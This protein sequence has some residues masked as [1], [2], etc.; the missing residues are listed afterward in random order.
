M[1]R[2]FLAIIL[3][4][5]PL[6]T[7]ITLAIVPL[8]VLAYNPLVVEPTEP[9]AIIPIE[10]DPY[11]EHHYLGSLEEY[12]EM[13]ELTTEVSMTLKFSIWQ[14]SSRKAVPFGLILV[15]QNDDD[16]G[17]TEL[18]R[19]S[20]PISEWQKSHSGALGMTFLKSKT[21]EQEIKPGTYRIEVSTPD[22]TGD[23]LLLIGEEP[24]SG[25]SLSDVRTIQKNFGYTVVHLLFSSFVYIPLGI[26]GVLY[27]IYGFRRYRTERAHAA[28][29]S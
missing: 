24:E 27:G 11:I 16:G 14:K 6:I 28:I 22:N 1:W 3:Y 18:V 20:Q 12:P 4:M 15:R 19:L 5:K 13:Y 21:I 17:V 10:G 9:Y 2:R 7:A 29:S 8:S 23:Y 26:L 25:T